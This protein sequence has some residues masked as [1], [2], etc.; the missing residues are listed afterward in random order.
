MADVV[1]LVFGLI[2][3]FLPVIN[4]CQF[5]CQEDCFDLLLNCLKSVSAG[6]KIYELKEFEQFTRS[7]GRHMTGCDAGHCAASAAATHLSAYS[8]LPCS[9]LHNILFAST[10][11]PSST[12]TPPFKAPSRRSFKSVFCLLLLLT[13]GDI[14]LNPGPNHRFNHKNVQF[15]NITFGCYNAQ[16]AAHKAALVHDIIND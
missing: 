11:Q 10:W 3:S 6:N 4:I 9:D 8:P 7:A 16:S 1:L 14:E 13:A 2:L 15:D 5:Q 12:T